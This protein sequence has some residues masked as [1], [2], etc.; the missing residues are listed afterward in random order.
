MCFTTNIFFRGENL[1]L[2]LDGILFLGGVRTT[3]FGN[4]PKQI[5]SKH[6]YKVNT[7]YIKLIQVSTSKFHEYS[8]NEVVFIFCPLGFLQGLRSKNIIFIGTK[9]MK[10]NE[11]TKKTQICVFVQNCKKTEM[12]I[13]AFCVITFEPIII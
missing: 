8:W 2:D 13:F 7:L 12:E 5:V 6:G 3:M 1:H 11:K 9:V 10:Q 4:L